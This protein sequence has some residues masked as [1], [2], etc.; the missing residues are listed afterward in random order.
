MA[1][2]IRLKRIGRR[3]RPFYRLVVM[4]ERSRRDGAAIEQLGW[5]NPL[6]RNDQKNF[7][8]NDERII[9]WLK[10][11]AQ[12]TETAHNLLKRTGLTYRWHLIR[13]GLDEKAVEKEM[14]KWALERVEVEKR[15]TDKASNK[16]EEKQKVAEKESETAA[17][18][19]VK[20][21]TPVKEETEAKVTEEV[22]EEKA[23]E[24]AP[25]EE[26]EPAEEE[27][28]VEEASDESS[29]T[30]EASTK[31]KDEPEAETD[32]EEETSEDEEPESEVKEE[33][34]VEEKAVETTEEE[35]EPEQET[36]EA[37]EDNTENK[38]DK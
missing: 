9:H 27:A 16:A 3:N 8:L 30:E 24:E 21:E 19:E 35:A 38:S 18:D 11:G 28:P 20:K 6:E 5:F 33:E 34:P 37:S 15:R 1:T 31:E 17:A 14:K 13:Q 36:D 7:A 10:E 2:K 29:E 4:D 12:T 23:E 25:A 32:V 26:E 22:V